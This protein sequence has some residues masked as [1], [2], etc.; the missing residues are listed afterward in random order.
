MRRREEGGE[1]ESERNGEDEDEGRGGVDGRGETMLVMQVRG[2]RAHTEHTT[3][4]ASSNQSSSK[5][6]HLSV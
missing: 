2:G 6:V 4:T 3:P 5:L 1:S